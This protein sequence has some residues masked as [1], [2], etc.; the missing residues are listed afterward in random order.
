MEKGQLRWI[1]VFFLWF[2]SPFVS[3]GESSSM[4]FVQIGLHDISRSLAWKRDKAG[5]ATH[6]GFF[7]WFFELQQKLG[8][9]QHISSP[10]LA[11]YSTYISG[12]RCLARGNTHQH[13]TSYA[14]YSTIFGPETRKIHWSHV[15]IWLTCFLKLKP[16]QESIQL[17][18]QR[19]YQYQSIWLNQWHLLRRIHPSVNQ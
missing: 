1:G 13:A 19:T 12:I 15:Q 16:D 17:F 10:F 9:E 5:M 8:E 18:H 4:Y 11:V 6:H 7:H 14:T 3:V 2:L